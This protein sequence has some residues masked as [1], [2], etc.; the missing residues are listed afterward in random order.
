M[1]KK[2]TV[3]LMAMTTII[4]WGQKQTE[5][6]SR[7]ALTG[8]GVVFHVGDI[9]RMY[10]RLMSSGFVLDIGKRFVPKLQAGVGLM[11]SLNIDNNYLIDYLNDEVEEYNPEIYYEYEGVFLTMPIYSWVKYDFGKRIASPF[12][13]CGLGSQISNIKS[14]KGGLYR[15]I[16]VGCRIAMKKVALSPFAG[17]YNEADYVHHTGGGIAFGIMVEFFK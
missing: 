14:A 9:D 5:G 1:N 4:A 17:Y 12:V 11:P 2:I 3:L 16:N 7:K 8:S 13:Y 15:S 6:E 10:G